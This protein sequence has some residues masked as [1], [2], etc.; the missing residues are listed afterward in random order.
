MGYMLVIIKI[1]N[2]TCVLHFP[3]LTKIVFIVLVLI[4]N[5]F[6]KAWDFDLFNYYYFLNLVQKHLLII[7]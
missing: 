2:L 3:C 5:Y 1:E 7:L 4:V 6:E